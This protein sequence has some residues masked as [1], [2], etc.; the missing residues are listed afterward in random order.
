[1]IAQNCQSNN[2]FSSSAALAH[3][4]AKFPT[5]RVSVVSSGLAQNWLERFSK[6]FGLQKMARRAPAPDCR[7]ASARRI[8]MLK[9]EEI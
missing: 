6:K 7:R 4:Y 3:R 2:C 1:M 9:L 8:A 5:V